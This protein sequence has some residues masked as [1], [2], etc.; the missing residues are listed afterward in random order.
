LPLRKPEND[1]YTDKYY[2]YHL[3]PIKR[4][5]IPLF[6]LLDSFYPHPSIHLPNHQN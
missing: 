2:I 4:I 6:K 3:F 1:H 5:L